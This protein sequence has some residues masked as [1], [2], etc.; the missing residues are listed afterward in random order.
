[1]EDVVASL[2]GLL[3]ALVACEIRGED[4]EP[5]AYVRLRREHRTHFALARE[6][7]DGRANPIAGLQKL[8]QAPA[9]QETGA[10][11]DEH[12]LVAI[13][14]AHHLA[15]PQRSFGPQSL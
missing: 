10:P 5:V 2:H 4:R 8:D 15:P 14:F 6:I 9:A 1:M 13:A 11:C 12:G 3:P 7:A